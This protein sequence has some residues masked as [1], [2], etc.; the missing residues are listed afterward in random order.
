MRFP[1]SSFSLIGSGM[2]I[3]VLVIVELIAPLLP[4]DL[5]KV[6]LDLLVSEEVE[7]SWAVVIRRLFAAVMFTLSSAF[8]FAAWRVI[9]LA[10]VRVMLLAI[11]LEDVDLPSVFV[12][13]VDDFL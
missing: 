7:K 10:E 3:S 4:S 12:I 8:S 5:A 2:K 13:S 1:A 9:S 11:R 6:V